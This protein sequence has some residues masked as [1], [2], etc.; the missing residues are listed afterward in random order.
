MKRINAELKKEKILD[1]AEA[2]FARE[3]FKG[4]SI[5]RISAE[6]QCNQAMIHYYFGSKENL[7]QEVFKSRWLNR[8]LKVVNCFKEA[9]AKITNPSPAQVIEAYARAYV[10]GPLTDPEKQIQRLLVVRELASPSEAFKFVSEEIIWPFTHIFL[11]YLKPV[12]QET[13]DEK[14]L[15]FKILSVYG[16]IYYFTYSTAIVSQISQCEYN[17]EFKQKIIENVVEFSLHGLPL[18]D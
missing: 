13:T 2:L 14:S 18:K 16:M 4:V 11:K 8:E 7:Y 3:G 9:L 1:C 15:I 6:A 10:D 17:Q 5:R 12:I